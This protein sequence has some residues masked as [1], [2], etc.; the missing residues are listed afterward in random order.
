MFS[1]VGVTGPRQ[2]GKSTMLQH[3]F[4]EYPFTTFDDPAE[5]FAF[6]TDPQGFLARFSGPVIFDE[7]Q[8]VP[9]LFRYI[10]MSIDENPELKGRFL[11]TGSNQFGFL[12]GA[13]ESLAGRIGL[14]SLLPFETGEMSADF[15][16]RQIWTGS[17]P[18]PV[19][20]NG[21]GLREWYSSYFRTYLEKD[22]RNQFDIGK[23]SD[24]QV[25]VRMLAA[26]TGQEINTASLAKEVGVSAKTVDAWI[27]VLEAGYIVFKLQP[28]H[29]NIGKRLIKRAK[30]YFWDTGLVSWLTG[31]QSAPL[32]EGGPLKGPLFENLV[33][34]ECKKR[35]LHTGIENVFMFYRDN[36]G[37]EID[38]LVIDREHKKI[39]LTEIK[40]GCTPKAEWSKDI[41]RIASLLQPVFQDF[42]FDRRIIYRGVSRPDWPKSGTSFI[43]W[44]DLA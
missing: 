1:A 18:S 34:S 7:V 20:N 9:D 25:L 11:L 40:A 33:V 26:R 31:I 3:V 44:L 17:Y 6:S 27:S 35:A 2:S 4:P 12:K 13:G 10:K 37:N 19:M 14:L 23:L 36:G 29:A 38:L 42:S 39:T 41:D 21:E 8:R 32:W 15:Q 28:F 16:L 5:E 22:I 30:L 43:N 24:F